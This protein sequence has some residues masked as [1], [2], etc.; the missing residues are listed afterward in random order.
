MSESMMTMEEFEKYYADNSHMTVKKLRELGLVALLCDCGEKGCHGWKMDTKE[1]IDFL[2]TL[3]E[4]EVRNEKA[5]YGVD[6][7][8]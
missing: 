7:S 2:K 4:S 5:D 8:R 6:R 3:E 1:R